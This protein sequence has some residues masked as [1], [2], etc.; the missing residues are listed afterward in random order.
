M[1]AG[2]VFMSPTRNLANSNRVKHHVNPWN[3][4]VDP[5]KFEDWE[6][7]FADEIAEAGYKLE[8]D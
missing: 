7:E 5:H 2:G 8:R 4:D 1:H 3:R 6:K